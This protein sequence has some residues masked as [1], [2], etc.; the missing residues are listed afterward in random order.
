M[1]FK[2][3][4]R[5]RLTAL[6][7]AL[8][9]ALLFTATACEGDDGDQGP[10][11]PPGPSGSDETD[12]ELTQGEA[13]PG[14]EIVVESVSGGTANGGRFEV[15]NRP[16]IVYRI[17]KTDG[18]DWD[19]SELDSGR[20]IVSGPTFNYQRVILE[21]SD[22][23]TA[24]VDRGDG[25]YAYT[26]AVPI[27]AVYAPPLNDTP[28]YGPDDGELTGQPLLDGTYT[29][30]LTFSWNYT[31]DGESENESGNIA[32]DFVVGDTGDVIPRE[33]VAIEN[34]NRCHDQLRIHGGKREEVTLCVL[35]HTSGAESTEPVGASIDFKVMIHKLH[36]GKH[37]PS[38]LGVTTNPDGSRNYDATPIPYVVGGTDFSH[39]GFPAWPQ[40][41]VPL[42]RDSGYAALSPENQAKEDMIRKGPSNCA[43]CHGDPDGDGPLPAPAQ[44][45][46]IYEQPA[47]QSCASCHD[48]WNFGDPYTA[49]GQTMGAQANNANC[50]LCHA[51]SGN[52]LA[53]YDAH[54]HPLSDPTFDPGLNFEVTNLIEA[55][56]NNGDGT[57]DPGEKIQFSLVIVD[58]LGATVD[59]AD[60]SNSTLVISGPTSNYNLLLNTSIPAAA[61]TGAQPFDV[62]VPMT[63]QLERAGVSTAALNVFTTA[64]APHWNVTGALTSVL[65]RTGIAGGNST[66][67]A[68]SEAP[69]NYVDVVSAAGFARDDY[70]VVDDGAGANEEYVRIQYVDGNRLWF[71][72]P[73][74][75][76]YKAGLTL[77]HANGAA[78]REVTIVTKTAGVDFSVNAAAGSIQELV[79]FGNGATVIAS[80]TT[81]FVM[82]TTYPLTINASPDLGEETGEWTGKSIVDGTYTLGVWSSKTLTL[83]LWGETNSYKSTADSNNVDF[84]VG[85]ADSIDPYDL[86]ASGSSCYNCHQDMAFHGYGR[87]GY[88]SCVLCHGSAGTEDRPQSVAANAPATDG[89][90]IN[91]RTMLHKIHMGSSL[92]NASSYDVVGFAS[93]AYP[94]N[95]ATHNYAEVN[96]PSLPGGTANCVKCHGND[97]WIEPSQRNHPTEQDVP[98]RRWAAVCAACHDSTDARAHINV[99][100]DFMGNES[101]GVCH[102]P[103]RDLDVERVHQSY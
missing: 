66:L 89:V 11:G 2:P 83:D 37:L 55:G 30:G 26:F 18:S 63:V 95:F 33:V 20:A 69:Q 99:N 65:V 43:V 13:L 94:D 87:R 91:F 48:D 29:I 5:P 6:V 42:P 23:L 41:S 47:R 12:D 76:S 70:I 60:I 62:T 80:Y 9:F 92:T 52:P 97:A 101:C 50:T 100:T 102:G 39:V 72:S 75:S 53:V 73:A 3:N 34:C 19:L 15:G 46:V 98:V 16:T 77:A 27:P 64:F 71:S 7:C 68:A 14:V 84:L 54:L 90:T 32:Y 36:A 1:K 10:A 17:Q 45:A 22:L 67:S 49:N 8:S 56:T 24:S 58:D 59:P 31:V 96:F 78:V 57:I 44:A 103:G 74:S 35:C 81:D 82:P 21:Q 25:S 79:E 28:T 40:A 51:A 86:I 85:S 88:E 4:S 38:V 61:L 93:G